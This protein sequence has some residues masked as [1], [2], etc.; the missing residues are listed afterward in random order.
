MGVL[1]L[2]LL[3]GG[4]C[5]ACVC[6]LR[7]V[8]TQWRVQLAAR[9]GERQALSRGA[10]TTREQSTHSFSILIASFTDVAACPTFFRGPLRWSLH[11]GLHMTAVLRGPPQK[12]FPGNPIGFWAQCSSVY[13]ISL[14]PSGLDAAAV[15]SDLSARALLGLLGRGSRAL[16]QRPPAKGSFSHAKLHISNRHSNSLKRATKAEVCSLLTSVQ[17]TDGPPSLDT[18]ARA[19]TWPCFSPHTKDC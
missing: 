9:V 16:A 5:C 3:A 10:T 19:Q 15:S 14:A 12:F 1:L 2:L 17:S 13:C 11:M 18:L 7:G 8:R 6:A 4:E